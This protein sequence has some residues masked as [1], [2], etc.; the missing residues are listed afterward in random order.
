MHKQILAAFRDKDYKLAMILT[1]QH[2]KGAED[3][4]K[5]ILEK[6]E[7]KLEEDDSDD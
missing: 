2:Y 5:K 4:F 3:I 7:G 6:K 1:E